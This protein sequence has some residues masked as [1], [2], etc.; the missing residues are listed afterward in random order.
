MLMNYLYAN[1]LEEEAFVAIKET[2]RDALTALT[3][4]RVFPAPSYVYACKGSSV[5]FV[6]SVHDDATYR[7]H[8]KGHSAWFESVVQLELATEDHARQHFASRY[9]DAKRMFFA[10]GLGQELSKVA[11]DIR[12]QFDTDHAKATWDHFLNGVYGV[13]TRDGQPESVFKK[14]ALVMFI[15]HS[16]ANGPMH[17]S[18]VQLQ[19]L[20][21]AVAALDEVE[22]D[23]APHEVSQTSRQRCI[24]DVRTN[25]LGKIAA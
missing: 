13:C 7:F 16:V 18:Q 25:I 22:S 21:R 5:S 6:S 1:F 11:P 15:D 20:E 4:A 2:T 14:Q 19:R 10:N 12:Q 3:Q 9:D 24:I 17:S 8:L 23:F